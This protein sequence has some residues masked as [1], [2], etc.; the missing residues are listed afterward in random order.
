MVGL[1]SMDTQNQGP[2]LGYPHML[3]RNMAW[4]TGRSGL[5]RDVDG[6]VI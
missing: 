4:K 2:T 1:A 5:Q 3:S 6:Q